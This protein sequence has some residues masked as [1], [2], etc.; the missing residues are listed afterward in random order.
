MAVSAVM[1]VRTAAECIT[2]IRAVARWLE[3]DALCRAAGASGQ[4]HSESVVD[5]LL[6]SFLISK[7]ALSH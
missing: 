4:L 6:E 5:A 3:A 1:A 2:G 7:M